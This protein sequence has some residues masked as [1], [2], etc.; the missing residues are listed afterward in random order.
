MRG[1]VH[2]RGATWSASWDEP[3]GGDGKRRQRKKGGFATRK[4]AQVHL[5]QVLASIDRHA[6]VQPERM[7][8]ADYLTQVW[9]PGL[10]V[11][12]STR[13]AYE[14]HVRIYLVPRLGHVP[15]QRLSR[16][17]LRRMFAELAIS[18]IRKP[19]SEAT[20]RRVHATVR[21][22]LNAALADDL[23]LRNPA[24]GLK[25][26]VPQRP[27]IT[28]WSTEELRQFLTAIEGDPLY[29][30]YHFIAMTGVRR[31]EAAGLRWA[32]VDLP[33]GRVAIRRQLSQRGR[34][35]EEGEPKTRRGTRSVALDPKTVGVL[36]TLRLRQAQDRLAWGAAYKASDLVFA[37]E[38]GSSVGPDHISG[39]FNLLVRK[40]GLKRI[41][42]HDLRHTHATLMLSQGVPA[43][44]VSE[45]LGH[46]SIA[47][48]LDTY[49]H[50]LPALA[51]EAAV[52]AAEA[53]FGHG[54]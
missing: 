40:T 25:L 32:D 51:E 48:T 2:K 21:A 31:G 49:S 50:V 20:L 54:A 30:V 42:L 38:N 22:A 7:T 9:L 28:V 34:L 24:V 33:A 19:L 53:V 29:P 1:H 15:L 44:A 5:T 3:R 16:A 36:T 18:G 8:L 14:S 11:R 41:R 35:L 47:L 39:H 23:I 6:Y 12:P 43:K 52:R 37:R 45:R 4:E 13:L 46:S 26:E 17:D 27:E 10:T